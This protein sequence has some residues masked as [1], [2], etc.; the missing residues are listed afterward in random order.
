MAEDPFKDLN[1]KVSLV[2]QF[3][4]LTMTKNEV[5][6]QAAI[7]EFL[8][9]WMPVLGYLQSVSLQDEFKLEGK[10]LKANLE[11]DLDGPAE[12]IYMRLGYC[13][14]DEDMDVS[15]EPQICLISNGVSYEY[16]RVMHADNFDAFSTHR[17]YSSDEMRDVQAVLNDWLAVQ[18][19]TQ[20]GH[21]K[22]LSGTSRQ[23]R[24]D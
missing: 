17:E 4:C 3:A 19:V 8:S 13:D 14:A 23:F 7:D 12:R 10:V 6:A 20:L 2:R 18:I 24:F 1:K 22:V 15:I 11:C 21:G 5:A 9:R 16:I